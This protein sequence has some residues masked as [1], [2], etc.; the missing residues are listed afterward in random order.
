MASGGCQQSIEW[1][2]HRVATRVNALIL[3]TLGLKPANTPGQGRQG[4]LPKGSQTRILPVSGHR[5]PK[6]RDSYT[7]WSLV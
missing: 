3:P 5:K 7:P 2:I 4:F 1:P 6:P